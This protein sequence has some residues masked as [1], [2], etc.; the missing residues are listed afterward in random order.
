MCGSGDL[1]LLWLSVL[2][3]WLRLLWTD[4]LWL[5]LLQLWLLELWLW[6]LRY[7]HWSNGLLAGGSCIERFTELAYPVAQ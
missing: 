1:D 7:G 3:S 2:H 6:L 4:L 5:S